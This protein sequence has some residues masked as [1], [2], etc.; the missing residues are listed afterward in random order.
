MAH[1]PATFQSAYRAYVSDMQSAYDEQR[2]FV[3][4]DRAIMKQPLPQMIRSLLCS[5][6][7]LHDDVKIALVLYHY[8]K[9][10][11]E[12]TENER[13]I[14]GWL[15]GS[16]AEYRQIINALDQRPKEIRYNAPMA[17]SHRGPGSLPRPASAPTGPPGMPIPSA[18]PLRTDPREQ[19]QHDVPQP[20]LREQSDEQ[21][22]QAREQEHERI[23]QPL[24]Q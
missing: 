22:R 19:A 10:Q 5:D 20:D 17:A 1:L 6:V 8:A 9:H 11:I 16:G 12:R 14:L 23:R 15:L 3:P 24:V 21:Q 13:S 4:I 18:P 2:G 7:D